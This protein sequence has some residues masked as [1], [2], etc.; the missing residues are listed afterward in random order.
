MRT[1]LLLLAVLAQTMPAGITRTALL[2]NDTVMMARLR[3]APGARED[4][5]THPFAAVVVQIDAGEV[6]AR[7]GTRRETARREPGHVDFIAAEMPHA[8]ANA[9]PAPFD[10]VTVALKAGRARGGTQP[11]S[12]SPAGI[13]RTPLLDNAEARATRV[14]FGPGSREPVHSHPFDM[15]VV[16]VTAG[17]MEVLVGGKTETRDYAPG[18]VVWL[19]RDVPHAVANAGGRAFTVVSVGVK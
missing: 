11:P 18:E 19:P 13:T 3:M 17:T 8:A 4:V 2:E 16:Q 14:T 10:V 1:V 9:G 12:Q 15:V 7:V 6:E 5:H